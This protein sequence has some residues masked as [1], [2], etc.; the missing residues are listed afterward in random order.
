M[1]LT[2]EKRQLLFHTLLLLVLSLD[3]YPAYSR[4]LMARLATQLRLPPRIVDE[5]ETRI[6]WGLSHAADSVF[7]EEGVLKKNE[8]G[9]RERRPRPSGPPPS[10]LAP[11]LE[12]AKIGSIAGGSGIGTAAAATV[13]GTMGTLSDGGL[14]TCILFGLCGPRG[15]PAKTLDIFTKDIQDIGLVPLHGANK[16]QVRQGNTVAAQDRRLRLAITISGW[17]RPEEDAAGP[18]RVLGDKTEVYALSWEQ[19]ALEKIGSSL[20]TAMSSMAWKNAKKEFAKRNSE[21]IYFFSSISLP[22]M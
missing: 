18:W 21:L 1:Q 2:P 22:H 7:N 10:S 9:K 11:V 14:A 13:L 8:D 12:N 17:T 15:S 3:S 16:L 6:A 20:E 19:E 4:I 5:E